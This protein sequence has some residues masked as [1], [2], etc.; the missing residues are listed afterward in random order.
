[1]RRKTLTLSIIACFVM[2]FAVQTCYAQS[3]SQSS[4]S[5]VGSW[6]LTLTPTTNIS[7]PP[8]QV[9]GLANFTSDGGAIATASAIIVGV[10]PTITNTTL[11]SPT[12]AMGNWCGGGAVI[13]C[14]GGVGSTHFTLLSIITNPDGSLFATRTFTATVAISSTGDSF[15]GTY[16]YNVVDTSNNTIASGSGTISATLITRLCLPAS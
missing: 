2:Y 12:P 8:L 1:M 7:P 14:G 13:M 6:Q 9:A 15:C 4:T 11:S 3:P 16:N 5:L 10:V